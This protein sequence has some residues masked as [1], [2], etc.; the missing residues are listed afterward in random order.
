MSS[1]WPFYLVIALAAFPAPIGIFSF[2][3]FHARTYVLVRD[4][5]RVYAKVGRQWPF[6]FNNER[7][8]AFVLR[9]DQLTGD[10]P[11]IASNEKALLLQHR[12]GMKKLLLRTFAAMFGAFALAILLLLALAA[13][14][15]FSSK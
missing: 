6:W 1:E 3:A 2:V 8:V 13:L 4:I 15:H 5:Q 11:G 9:P 14:G 7:Q 12:R 10:E